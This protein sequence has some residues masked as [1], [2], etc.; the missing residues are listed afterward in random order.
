MVVLAMIAAPDALFRPEVLS[1][2]LCLYSPT[3]HTLQ[4][5]RRSVRIPS[6]TQ[7]FDVHAEPQIHLVPSDPLLA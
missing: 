5:G 1:A 6:A 4:P 2:L 3:T 7:G